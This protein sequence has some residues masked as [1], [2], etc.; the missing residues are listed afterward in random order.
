MYECAGGG[1]RRARRRWIAACVCAVRAARHVRPGRCSVNTCYFLS[2]A[3]RVRHVHV[4][5]VRDTRT[6]T[7]VQRQHW[8]CTGERVHDARCFSRLAYHRPRSD[9][10]ASEAASRRGPHRGRQQ[11]PWR[12]GTGRAEMRAEHLCGHKPLLRPNP[13]LRPCSSV[14]GGRRGV[15]HG[16]MRPQ[17]PRPPHK[18]QGSNVARFPGRPATSPP[19]LVGSGKRRQAP[20]TSV[21]K[22]DAFALIG[23]RPVFQGG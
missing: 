15:Q 1:W 18:P 22:A 13:L 14:A 12:V 8:R 17:L 5:P 11:G 3:S 23:E 9:F 2:N 20:A 10:D 21:R 4:R 6:H 7:L 16:V 19:S